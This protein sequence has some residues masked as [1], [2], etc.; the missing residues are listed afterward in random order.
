MVKD[1]LL[2]FELPVGKVHVNKLKKIENRATI[3]RDMIFQ[4][5]VALFHHFAVKGLKD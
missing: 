2:T 4:T 5:C 3:N 1:R